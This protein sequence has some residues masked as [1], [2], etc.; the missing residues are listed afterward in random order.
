MSSVVLDV[1]LRCHQTDQG[2]GLM[3]VELICDEDPGGPWID[4]NGFMM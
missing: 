3:S 2:L 1:T 4:L